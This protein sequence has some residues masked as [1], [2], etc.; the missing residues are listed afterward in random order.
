MASRL[1]ATRRHRPSHT[2]GGTVMNLS[3]TLKDMSKMRYL[4]IAVL[5]CGSVVCPN[6]W[7]ASFTWTL[8][9]GAGA[10]STGNSMTF[11]SDQSGGP[12]VTANAWYLTGLGSPNPNTTGTLQKAALGQYSNGLAVCNV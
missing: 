7:A 11:G 5:A 4:A 2:T 8:T 6:T 10:G 9:G 1:R 3:F 12:S